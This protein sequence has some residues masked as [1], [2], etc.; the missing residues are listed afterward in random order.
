MMNTCLR[1]FA[2]VKCNFYAGILILWLKEVSII[3]FVY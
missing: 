1:D 3:D 2:E